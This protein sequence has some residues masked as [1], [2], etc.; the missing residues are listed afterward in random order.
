MAEGLRFNNGLHSLRLWGNVFSPL[1]SKSWFELLEER[2][3]RSAIVVRARPLTL[4]LYYHVGRSKS[5]NH[6]IGRS[7]GEQQQPQRSSHTPA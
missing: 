2:I 3:H 6:R 7:K 1:S 5:V 4:K